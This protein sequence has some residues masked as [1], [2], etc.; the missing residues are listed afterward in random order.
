MIFLSCITQSSITVNSFSPKYTSLTARL[1]LLQLDPF[2]NRSPEQGATPFRCRSKI[3]RCL[4]CNDFLEK[5][6]LRYIQMQLP[7]G[8]CTRLRLSRSGRT[9]L[10]SYNSTRKPMTHRIHRVFLLDIQSRSQARPIRMLKSPT[11]V[12]GSCR[13]CVSRLILGLYDRRS[14]KK[15]T[16]VS[17]LQRVDSPV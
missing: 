11:R 15:S 13:Y 12:F 10:E 16:Q 3:F 4:S 8:R 2:Q 1:T 6:R 5:L 7:A 17:I 14:T 9:R